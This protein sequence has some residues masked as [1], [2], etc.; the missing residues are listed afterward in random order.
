MI[1]TTLER[2]QNTLLKHY[3]RLAAIYEV[4]EIKGN[5][6]PLDT[7]V[8]QHALIAYDKAYMKW[9]LSEPNS[10]KELL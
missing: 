9:V 4:E 1:P 7:K 10:I 6:K 8:L 2:K 5:N 3:L